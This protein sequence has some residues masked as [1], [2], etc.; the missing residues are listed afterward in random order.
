MSFFDYMKAGW[1]VVKLKVEVIEK[2]AADEK[3]FIPAIGIV[4]IGGACMAFG[5]LQPALVIVTAIL[6]L[7]GMFIDTGIMHFV[8]TSFF[9]GKGEFKGLFS[10]LGCA[11]I[12]LWV[13]IIPAAGLPL[14]WLAA[15]W[16]CVVAVFTIEKVYSIERGKAVIVV[17]VPVVIGLLLSAFMAMLGVF[18][19]AMLGA[20]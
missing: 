9:G 5:M 1:E 19:A 4:A 20:T 6:V 17:A 14:F 16:L 11:S 15:L 13:G 18:T 3:A 8:A 2:L 12:I 10:P 7:I